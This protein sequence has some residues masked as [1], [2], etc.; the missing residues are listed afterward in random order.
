M[1]YFIES[2]KKTILL[3][4]IRQILHNYQL[5]LL[6]NKKWLSAKINFAF[7]QIMVNSYWNY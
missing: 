1:T 4:L 7:N 5:I 3:K 6:E 2:D